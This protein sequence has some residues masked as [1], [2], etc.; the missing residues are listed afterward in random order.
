MRAALHDLSQ[1][2]T[3]IIVAHRLSTVTHADEIYVLD[4]G[5]VVERGTHKALM[6]HDGLYA[7]MFQ[8]QKE[9]YG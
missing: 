4:D 3:T 6:K 8:S 9:S 2:K 7:A 5:V 1:G